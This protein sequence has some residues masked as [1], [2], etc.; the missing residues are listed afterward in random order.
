MEQIGVGGF[1][2][3]LSP[4]TSKEFNRLKALIETAPAEVTSQELFWMQEF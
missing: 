1:F 4:E 2:F 3:E